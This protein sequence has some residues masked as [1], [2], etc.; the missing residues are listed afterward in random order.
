[1]KFPENTKVVVKAKAP[2]HASKIGWVDFYCI[3]PSDNTV[4]LRTEPNSGI[5][6]ILIAVSHDHIS[7][8][9]VD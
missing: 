1:M 6:Q 2:F 5:E 3:G 7:K 9:E 4:V 8:I